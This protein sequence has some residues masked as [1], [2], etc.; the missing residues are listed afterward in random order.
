MFAKGSGCVPPKASEDG[1]KFL[2]IYPDGSDAIMCRP[3]IRANKWLGVK[4][5]A[6]GTRAFMIGGEVLREYFELSKT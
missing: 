1:R 4:S 6:K 3:C 5:W 2:V